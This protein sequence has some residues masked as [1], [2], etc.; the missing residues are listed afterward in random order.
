MAGNETG[1]RGQEMIYADSVPAVKI[2][3]SKGEDGEKFNPDKERLVKH[4]WL[5]SNVEDDRVEEDWYTK[6]WPP[7]AHQ[8]DLLRD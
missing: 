7:Q 8:E 2:L 3:N 5:I 6:V 1:A 4:G